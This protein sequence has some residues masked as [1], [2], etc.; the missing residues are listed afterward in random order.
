MK[1]RKCMSTPVRYVNSSQTVQEAA[2]IMREFDVT[3]LVVQTDD[4]IRGFIADRDIIRCCTAEGCDPTATDVGQF[5]RQDVVRCRED[6]NLEDAVKIMEREE[7]RHLL[8]L[9]EQ[10]QV[11]G[12]LSLPDLARWKITGK[13]AYK[14]LKAMCRR[15]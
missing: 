1:V 4:S 9:N 5:T 14:V 6:Q 15:Q 7:T 3:E 12:L 8:V 13:A 11:T 10:E 2:A